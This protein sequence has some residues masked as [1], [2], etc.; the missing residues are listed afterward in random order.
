VEGGGGGGKGRENEGELEDRLKISPS[1]ID[2]S[3]TDGEIAG[4]NET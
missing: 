3:R 1:L 2:L 4:S